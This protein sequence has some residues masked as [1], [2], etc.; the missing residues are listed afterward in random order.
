MTLIIGVKCTDGVVIAADSKAIRGDDETHQQKVTAYFENN[1]I[2]GISGN[3]NI[4]DKLNRVL[5]SDMNAIAAQKPD[6][7]KTQPFLYGREDLLI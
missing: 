2:L 3:P 1:V 5:P 4:L 6:K 7:E